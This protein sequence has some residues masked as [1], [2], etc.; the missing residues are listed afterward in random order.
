[1]SPRLFI[2]VLIFTATGLLFAFILNIFN[3]FTL[4]SAL[5][6]K[7]FNKPS[8]ETKKFFNA[9]EDIKTLREENQ[10]LNNEVLKLKNQLAIQSEIIEKNQEIAQQLDKAKKLQLESAI[11]ATVISRSPNKMLDSIIIDAGTNKG[12][13]VGDAALVDGFLVGIVVDVGPFSSRIELLTNP[14]TL[15][16]VRLVDSRARGLLQ[17]SLQGI[18]VNSIPSNITTQ[19]KELVLS[20][21]QDPEVMP[22]LPI[23]E[24]SDKISAES[25]ILKTFLIKSPVNFNTFEF[26]V[27]IPNN[28]Q[29][30][31]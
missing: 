2:A 22:G 30:E 8:I 21:S 25:E 1:M 19:E 31:D 26:L 13:G 11:T 10:N 9:I 18:E 17:G 4:S 3:V 20:D 28:A 7:I 29:T 23:G 5:P 27:V 12:V 24:L 15:I 6:A 16:P 14:K